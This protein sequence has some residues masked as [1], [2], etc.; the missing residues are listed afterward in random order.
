[1]VDFPASY[2][3]LSEGNPFLFKDAILTQVP[4][5]SSGC[6]F[7]NTINWKPL[8]AAIQLPKQKWY[9]TLDGPMEVIGS[10]S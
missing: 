5:S 1:M 4:R 10:R 8:K 3:S 9:T 7:S 2:V 6:C